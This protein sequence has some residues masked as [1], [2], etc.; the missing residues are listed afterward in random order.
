MKL[1][2]KSVVESRA[3]VD[4]QL[5][6]PGDSVLIIRHRPRWLLLKCPCGCEDVIS[7]N[8]DYRAGKSWRL[9]QGKGNRLSLFP[10]VWRDTGCLSHFIVR[11][12]EIDLF[13][14]REQSSHRW[15]PKVPAKLL[16]NRIRRVWPHDGWVQCTEI[17]DEL[18]E[19]PW[20]V[21]DACRNLVKAGVLEEGE[22][23]LGH[24]FRRC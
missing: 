14:D 12:G 11:N 17:A 20:D 10:S 6:N 2:L 15:L 23:D 16:A 8:V 21:L 4:S 13:G 3:Q 7:L 5:V 9:Y 22:R 18:D 19:L 24:T 1:L